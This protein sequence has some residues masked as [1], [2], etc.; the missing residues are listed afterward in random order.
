MNSPTLNQDAI[1]RLSQT[2][3]ALETLSEQAIDPGMAWLLTM[4]GNEIAD[5][6]GTLETSLNQ[7]SSKVPCIFKD[8]ASNSR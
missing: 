1:F 4:L 7:I 6:T 3:A 8:Q 2:A 5:C